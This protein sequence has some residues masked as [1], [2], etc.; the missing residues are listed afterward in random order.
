MLYNLIWAKGKKKTYAELLFEVLIGLCVKT[1]NDK[2]FLILYKMFVK[3]ITKFDTKEG[4]SILMFID[5]IST[6]C[7]KSNP[8]QKFFSK[9]DIREIPSLTM[10]ILLRTLKITLNNGET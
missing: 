5:M 2:Y 3:N 9:N 8:V 4:H 1:N 7:N 10:Q 6:P